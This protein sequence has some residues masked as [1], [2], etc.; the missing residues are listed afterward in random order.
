VTT[1]P[2]GQLGLFEAA[3]APMAEPA[4][5]PDALRRCAAALPADFRLGTSSWAFP[6]WAG[7]VWARDYPEALLARHGL[8]AYASHPL[9]RTVSL[10]RSYYAP[11]SAGQYAGYAAQVPDGFRFVVK[12]PAE[13]TSPV[14]QRPSALTGRRD[15]R[16]FLDPEVARRILVE[17]V[18]AGLG[19]K[20]GLVLLQIPPMP[21]DWVRD[22]EPFAERL[23]GLL[24][25]LPPSLPRAVELRNAELL[26][27]PVFEALERSGTL[28]CYTVHPRAPSID[29]QHACLPAELAARGP[30]VLRWNLRP[31]ETYAG[32]KARFAPFTH[33]QAED[34]ENRPSILAL[35]RRALAAGRP[36][37]V[38]ANKN[39]EGC[40]PAPLFRLAEEL[41]AIG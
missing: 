24:Q 10:D 13:L 4:A 19:A 34:R 2:R 9:L 33:L 7:Q 40:A 8:G 35:C 18:R 11:L 25:S 28:F 6:G 37:Y 38:I 29:V 12:A 32:A 1:D 30:L 41:A 20:L 5:V 16:R 31:S 36:A 14:L 21:P 3:D 23:A 27:A 17:P 39:A 26:C 22:P 15:N